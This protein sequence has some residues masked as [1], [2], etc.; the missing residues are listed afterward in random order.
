MKSGRELKKKEDYMKGRE[1]KYI[2]GL[3]I[4]DYRGSI[5]LEN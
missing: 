4:E 3:K 5:L 1:R 2:F